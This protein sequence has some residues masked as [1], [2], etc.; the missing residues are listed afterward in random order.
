MKRELERRRRIGIVFIVA[1]IIY[2]LVYG[3]SIAEGQER[4]DP[5]EEFC[6]PM[7]IS[8]RGPEWSTHIDIFCDGELVSESLVWAITHGGWNSPMPP[9]WLYWDLFEYG[10]EA[11]DE[12][13][14]TVDGWPIVGSLTF[15]PD[16]HAYFD[17]VKEPVRT[18]L[19]F[20]TM[21]K[22]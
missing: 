18:T 15:V 4:C 11:G 9:D 5:A 13:T 20:P 7:E 3:Y 19:Y 8:G 16:G 1:M 2:I 14:F 22:E 6:H 21:F 10:C 12:I 17:L